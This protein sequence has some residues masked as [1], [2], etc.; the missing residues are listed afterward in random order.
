MSAPVGRSGAGRWRRARRGR[1][2]RVGQRRERADASSVPRPSTWTSQPSG[3]RSLGLAR[4]GE[5]RH[6]ATWRRRARGGAGQPAGPRRTRR[7][8]RGARRQA[9]PAPRSSR[10]GNVSASSLAPV[11]AAIAAAAEAGLA[12]RAPPSSNAPA[13]PTAAPWRPRRRLGGAP[14][15][16]RAA[17]ARP[18]RPPS[19]QRHV[20]R[21]DQRGDLARADRVPRRPPRPCRRPTS[22]GAL[23][24]CGSSPTRCRATR[25]DVGLE[26]SVVAACGRSRGRRRCSP[27]ACAPAARCAG[28]RGRCPDRVRGAAASPP[29]ARPSGRSRRP[30][31]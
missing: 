31:R 21:Q 9:G 2:D 7:G 6:R 8:T 13:R 3:T 29:A 20:G 18:A 24:P 26:R 5:E 15:P 12:Q 30:R 19:P 23:A 17:R 10:A 14:S 4:V 27:S 16:R 28:W 25:L 22:A 1:A 11:A